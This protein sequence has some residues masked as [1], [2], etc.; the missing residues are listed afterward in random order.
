MNSSISVNTPQG[1]T[2]PS[3]GTSRDMSLKQ[4]LAESDTAFE[5]LQ[6]QLKE[7]RGNG[8]RIADFLKDLPPE[9]IATLN[10][11]GVNR[12]IDVL[13][14]R[15]REALEEYKHRITEITAQTGRPLLTLIDGEPKIISSGEPISEQEMIAIKSKL[16]TPQNFETGRINLKPILDAKGET[17]VD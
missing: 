17:K 13:P 16:G 12:I 7:A 10:T 2:L 3:S 8:K 5:Q 15:Y 6:Q 9:D 1:R 11:P 14:G 4:A